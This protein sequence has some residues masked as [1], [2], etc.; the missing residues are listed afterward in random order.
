MF[1]AAAGLLTRH[2][3]RIAMGA[4]GCADQHPESTGKNRY[5]T[6]LAPLIAAADARPNPLS[7]NGFPPRRRPTIPA[8]AL[9]RQQV[10]SLFNT[11]A[12]TMLR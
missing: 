2:R 1:L 9:N 12:G 7:A 4:S 8:G 6:S 3:S 5:R 11:L 10:M